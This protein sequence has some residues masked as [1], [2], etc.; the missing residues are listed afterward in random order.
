MT[1]LWIGLISGTS[2]DGVDAVLVSFDGTDRPTL[3][4]ALCHRYPS[5]LRERLDE[6]AFQTDSFLA[7]DLARLD[8][9]VGAHFAEAAQALVDEAGVRP[10]AVA[11]IGSHGQTVFH[12]PDETPPFSLQLGSPALIAEAT[13]ID[14]IAPRLRTARCRAAL[15]AGE[16][17]G[18]QSR[19]HRE[20]DGPAGRPTQARDRLRHGP[21]QRAHGPVDRAPP[22]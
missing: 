18:A 2:M 8:A 4:A 19:R 21:G 12:A 11:A 6:A 17:S 14:V 10:T 9:A 7:L 16:S 3:R 13:G 5:A 20:S 1:D 15:T 22:G